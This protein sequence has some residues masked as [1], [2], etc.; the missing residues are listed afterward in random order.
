MMR[1]LIC[2]LWLAV[3]GLPAFGQVMLTGAFQS[4]KALEEDYF[5]EVAAKDNTLH[6][7]WDDRTEDRV[8]IYTVEKSLD[9]IRFSPVSKIKTDTLFDIHYNEYLDDPANEGRDAFWFRIKMLAANGRTLYSPVLQLADKNSPHAQQKLAP[10]P[11]PTGGHAGGGGPRNNN[12]PPTESPPSGGFYNGN[13][14]TFQ[15]QCCYWEE[16]Q[17]TVPGSNPCGSTA[18]WCCCGITGTNSTGNSS[19][20]PC[21]YDDCCVHQCA[22]FSSCSCS[23]PC[24]GTHTWVVHQ[25]TNYTSN[26]PSLS[27]SSIQ[28]ASC[29]GNADGSA[30]VSVSGGVAPF[31]I[32]WSNGNWGATASSLYAGTYTV[33]V[34]DDRQ[35]TDVIPLT[36]QDPG[37][38]TVTPSVTNETCF[39]GSDGSITLTVNGGTTPYSFAWSHGATAQNA[40]G[41]VQGTYTV[42]VTDANNCNVA[43]TATVTAG[44]PTGPPGIWTWT[45]VINNNWFKPCNWDKGT[46][47][48]IT[49][50]VLIPGGTPNNPTIMAGNGYCRTLEIAND[51]GGQLYLDRADGGKLTVEQ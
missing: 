4:P 35:C 15:G 1:T 47:P 11:T 50:D 9:G 3:A 31:G 33:T 8:K 42:V 22:Q 44:S 2:V 19:C 27:I 34:T 48:D 30:T 40:T 25:S 37:A 26:L 16:R 43:A 6:L 32:A 20:Q 13:S 18:N 46:V 29:G 39:P 23:W 49:K 36:L 28:H 45:G 10:A 5:F 7:V 12:C 51:N 38:I 41:L 24:C 21:G 17:Y 14:N